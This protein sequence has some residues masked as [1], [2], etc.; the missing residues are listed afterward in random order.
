MQCGFT[1][2][3]VCGLSNVFTRQQH[4]PLRPYLLSMGLPSLYAPP[5]FFN[6]YLYSLGVPCN[7]STC[8]DCAADSRCGW[9]ASTQTCSEGNTTGPFAGT[10]QAWDH[11]TCPCASSTDCSSCN[12][13]SRCGW[14][15][16]SQTCVRG[17]SSSP[18]FGTCPNYDYNTCTSPPSF[19]NYY[20]NIE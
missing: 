20:S 9:C 7:H 5:F 3:M 13:D 1:M 11:G 14:C 2:R 8:G 4:W 19:L 17:N 15:A 10:C 6:S 18:V 12:L 16:T